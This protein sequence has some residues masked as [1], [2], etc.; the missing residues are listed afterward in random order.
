MDELLQKVK[1]A[2]RI[3]HTALDDDLL[4]NIQACLLDLKMH[5]VIYAG[6][7]DALVQNAVKL[8]CKAAYTDDPAKAE[9][10]GQMYREM[11]NCLKL[12]EGYGWKDEVVLDD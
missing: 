12:A 10:Y 5:G 6:Q 3:K 11:R 4:D 2:L 1:T 9:K 7:E 8:Y